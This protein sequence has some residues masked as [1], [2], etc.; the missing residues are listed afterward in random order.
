M[1]NKPS[2][3]S[4]NILGSL[5]VISLVISSLSV[6]AVSSPFSSDSTQLMTQNLQSSSTLDPDKSLPT[7]PLSSQLSSGARML[8][9]GNASET[10]RSFASGKGAEAIQK[11]LGYYGTARV[12]LDWNRNNNWGHSSAD[13]LVPLYD[14][15]IS[16]MYIEGGI[17]KPEGRLTGNLGYGIRTFWENGWMFGGNVFFDED[18][19]RNNR[20]I[21]FGGEAWV[22]YLHFSANTY[23]N[24]TQWHNSQDL[25]NNWQEKPASGYDLRAEGWLPAY[26]Q[27][28]AKLIWEQYY[29]DQVALFD[30]EHRQH[31]PYAMTAGL[32]YTPVPILTLGLNQKQGQSQHDTQAVLEGHWT[33]GHNWGWH[34]N[35]NNVAQQRSLAGSRYDLVNRNNEI[36]MQYRKNP[37]DT[38]KHLE[39]RVIT[40]NSPADGVTNNVLLVQATNG[41]SQPVRG[42]PLSLMIVTGTGVTLT[43]SP[44]TT[45]DNGQA[46]V[47][48]VSSTQQTV[49]IRAQSGGASGIQD[50]HFSPVNINKITL[51]VS[52]DNAIA[53]GTSE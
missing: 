41:N 31:N 15:Q 20:R 44:S 17:R 12:Q 42:A 6:A 49:R 25:D 43:S 10:A 46:N 34:L 33:I 24:T 14:N 37:D 3:L 13:L 16:L 21:G 50:S 7:L 53:D 39:L 23:V 2:F 38:V 9:S 1:K 5:L 35:S 27:L 29:G 19:S 45:D 22:N 52:Q 11:W 18:F 51:A 28:G 8:A 32:E 36:V 26:P 48:L 40:D 47:T 4:K 30:K